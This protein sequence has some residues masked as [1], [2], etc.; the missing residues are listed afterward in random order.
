MNAGHHSKLGVGAKLLIALVVLGN[1]APALLAPSVG[2]GLV[3]RVPEEIL[4]LFAFPLGL[5]GGF[6]A[7]HLRA[8]P[9]A[10]RYLCLWGGL[11]LNAWLWGWVTYR[12]IRSVRGQ[13]GYG[14][15]LDTS[16]VM[17]RVAQLRQNHVG[18]AKARSK[19]LHFRKGFLAATGRALTKLAYFCRVR[20][21]HD[22]ADDQKA[23]RTGP[24]S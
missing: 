17:P 6:A 2:L 10:V 8:S 14:S 21:W 7:R 18:R 22:E 1:L 19:P 13:G 11:V 24:L 20:P 5:V 23:P 12:V 16:T 3:N 4:I 9:H 15:G